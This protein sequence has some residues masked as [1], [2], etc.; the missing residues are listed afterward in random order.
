MTIVS[1]SNIYTQGFG[2]KP[3]TVE[4]PHVDTRN[5]TVDDIGYVIGKR[6]INT[7]LNQVFS[8]TS[9]SQ[10]GLDNYA[11]WT[12]LLPAFSITGDGIV[13]ASSPSTVVMNEGC[14]ANSIIIFFLRQGG[15]GF[16]SVHSSSVMEGQFTFTTS[17]GSGPPNFNYI[18]VTPRG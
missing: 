2:S 13:I 15:S 9:I 1:G 11:N 4:V 6:W 10:S 17:F 5:P 8:L 18:I 12:S 7:S 14:H 3:Q 16:G